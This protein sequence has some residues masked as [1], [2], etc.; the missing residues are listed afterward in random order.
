MATLSAC[1]DGDVFTVDP[2][3]VSMNNTGGPDPASAAGKTMVRDDDEDPDT[4]FSW[5]V[6]ARLTPT[7]AIRDPWG[8]EHTGLLVTP[9]AAPKLPA[10][11]RVTSFLRLD[12][13]VPDA[14]EHVRNTAMALSPVAQVSILQ[15]EEVDKTFASIR[16]GLYAGATVVLVLVG[17]SLLVG[18][19]E[20]LRERRRTFAAL[21]AFGTRR[22]TM[23]RSIL[24][25]T[26]LPVALGLLVAAIMGSVLG[27][28]LLR[29]VAVKVR[30]D[31]WGV[32]TVSG[33][34]AAVVLLVTALSL[35]ALFRLMRPDGLR[36]E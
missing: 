13:A 24:W 29:I 25:Q 2:S 33:I 4:A 34:A 26:A 17:L 11:S 32:A 16:R 15:A 21:V 35:P 5:A 30:P 22:G 27:G 10:Q 31:W 12:P 3:S 28:V 1:Q 19:L 20:Q 18:I 9:A 8:R 14:D 23:A 7:R 6:P 36:F